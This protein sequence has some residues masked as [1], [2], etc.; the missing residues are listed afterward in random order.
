MC[1][2]CVAD[3]EELLLAAVARSRTINKPV[4]SDR[5]PVAA[6]AADRPPSWTTS[7]VVPV[8]LDETGSSRS[9]RNSQERHC[10]LG[11]DIFG[12]GPVSI[13]CPLTF[14][15]GP[16]P[17]TRPC[18][19]Y[20]IQIRIRSESGL[21]FTGKSNGLNSWA[22]SSVTSLLFVHVGR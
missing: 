17:R 1:V 4:P 18:S 10:D 13:S 3:A 22:W 7:E 14:G 12:L 8:T 15:F 11:N 21:G 16:R 20:R 5:R 19:N 6:A 9:R 2:V